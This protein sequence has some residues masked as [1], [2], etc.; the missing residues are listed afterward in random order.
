MTWPTKKQQVDA[1]RKY[2]LTER[3]E[4][5]LS[6]TDYEPHNR[7]SAAERWDEDEREDLRRR[8]LRGDS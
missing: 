4:R 6:A 2:K 8:G 7:N 1:D 3:Y 5:E